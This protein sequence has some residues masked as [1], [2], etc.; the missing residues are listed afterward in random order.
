MCVIHF[1]ENNFGKIILKIV[2][3]NK[4]CVRP[5]FI[6]LFIILLVFKLKVFLIYY[7]SYYLVTHKKKLQKKYSRLLYVN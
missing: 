1:K 4:C 6:Y 3:H 2:Y 7:Y 5:K